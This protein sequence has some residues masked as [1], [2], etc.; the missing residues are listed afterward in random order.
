MSARAASNAAWQARWAL[1]RPAARNARPAAGVREPVVADG[2]RHRQHARVVIY[3]PKTDIAVLYV[4]GLG[5]PTLKFASSPAHTGD[6]AVVAGYPDGERFTTAAARVGQALT[7]QVP[8]TSHSQE[9][10]RQ[11]YTVRADVQHGDSGGPS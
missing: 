8:G 7:A 5:L 10:T 1:S 4:P 2:P 6:D 3:D 11:I 9:V